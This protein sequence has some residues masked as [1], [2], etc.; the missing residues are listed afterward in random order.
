MTFSIFFAMAVAGGWEIWEFTT[1]QLLGFASQNNSLI[2][3]M[4]DIICGTVMGVIT[5]I[6]IYLQSK[7]KKIYFVDKIINEMNK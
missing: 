6:P 3:T 2:D 4:L 5:N 1:D 7:G